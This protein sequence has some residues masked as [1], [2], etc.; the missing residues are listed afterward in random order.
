[1]NLLTKDAEK[2][3]ECDQKRDPLLLWNVLQTCHTQV[4]HEV[5]DEERRLKKLELE[6]LQQWDDHGKV[7]SLEDHDRAWRDLY[8]EATH[9]SVTW[10]DDEIVRIYLR[11]VD[12]TNITH[13]LARILKPG[14]EDL[15][16]NVVD[17][18]YVLGGHNCSAEQT[19]QFE[20]AGTKAF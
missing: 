4:G 3:A 11:S 1:M 8:E 6:A 18:S 12:S 2:Y 10:A 7:L 16:K 19:N 15:P 14:A 9:M 13:D 20:S 17:A 5:S